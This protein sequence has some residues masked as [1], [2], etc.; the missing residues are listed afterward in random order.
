MAVETFDITYQD[1]EK[2][3]QGY[4]LSRNKAFVDSLIKTHAAI[5]GAKIKKEG[6]VLTDVINGTD[7]YEF[8][9][10][11]II[12]RTIA[13]LGRSFTHQNP[14]LSD[15][16]DAMATEIE[17]YIRRVPE[18]VAPS[19]NADEH[20]GSFRRK[21]FEQLGIKSSGIDGVFG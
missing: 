13:E 20:R 1:I 2:R 16:R 5:I 6:I 8:A 14:E 4:D 17:K 18:A 19:F 12:L 9:R 7:L 21:K 3:L 10:E 15:Q 11:V